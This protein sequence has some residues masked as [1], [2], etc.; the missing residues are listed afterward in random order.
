MTAEGQLYSMV[1][2]G[3]WMDIGQPKDFL[4]GIPLYLASVRKHAPATLAKGG[5]IL[6]NVLI[7]LANRVAL[8]NAT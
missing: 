4:A 5:N 3:F 2:D 6:E 8:P 1:L 7:V